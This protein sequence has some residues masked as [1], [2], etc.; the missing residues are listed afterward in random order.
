MCSGNQQT[1]FTVENIGNPEVGNR[2]SDKMVLVNNQHCGKLMHGM[3]NI[4]TFCAMNFQLL[5]YR[6][7]VRGSSC[8]TPCVDVGVRAT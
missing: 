6:D 7:E 2:C 5:A 3:Y 4:L 1:N 8:Y